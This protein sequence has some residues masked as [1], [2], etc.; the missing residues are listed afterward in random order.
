MLGV[1]PSASYHEDSLVLRSKDILA[2]F[3]DG[4]SEV[5]DADGNVFDSPK[6]LRVVEKN[7]HQS[8][9]AICVALQEEAA[10]FA[11]FNLRDDL[12]ICVLKFL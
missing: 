9:E 5:E 3:S 11:G 10:R 1:L 6:I 12:A 4:L 7:Q 8:A 2:C